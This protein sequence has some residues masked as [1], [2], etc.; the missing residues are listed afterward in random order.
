MLLLM[1]HKICKNSRK[2]IILLFENFYSG[3]KIPASRETSVQEE[4]ERRILDTWD[5][6]DTGTLGS[7]HKSQRDNGYANTF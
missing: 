1:A 5:T 7:S 6:G 2:F 3:L 4:S